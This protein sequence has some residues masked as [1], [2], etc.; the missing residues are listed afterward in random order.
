MKALALLSPVICYFALSGP[1]DNQPAQVDAASI[2]WSFDYLGTKR[3]FQKAGFP[4]TAAWKGNPT[5]PTSRTSNGP[6]WSPCYLT[7]NRA[8][9]HA[10][11]TCEPSLTLCCI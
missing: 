9:G 11:P 3:L 4:K 2:K 1:T 8:D 10:R 7:P 5:P 6:S